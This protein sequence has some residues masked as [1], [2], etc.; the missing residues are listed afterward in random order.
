MKSILTLVIA[1]FISTNTFSQLDPYGVSVKKC[2]TNNGTISYYEGVVDQMFLMLEQQ[3]ESQKVPENI[4]NEV[5]LV[6]IDAMKELS[7]M[8][9]S[10]YRGH[11]S[12]EDVKNMNTLYSSK[13]GKN[14]FKPEKLTE[15]DK[16]ALSEFYKS[17][18]GQK[19]LG[20]QESI[21][22]SMS[23]ISEI[24]SGDLYKSVI[25]KLSKKGFNL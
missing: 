10:A 22:N 13:A 2:I 19:V 24:W 5:K 20:S 16:L 1:L 21:T 4:W 25:N 6:K 15:S 11:F 3:F 7:Q 17:D 23:K 14:M 12:H 18:T 8:M 9:V